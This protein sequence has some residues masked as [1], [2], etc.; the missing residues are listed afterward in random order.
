[1]EK[2]TYTKQFKLGAAKM[3]VDEKMKASR[4]CK[5]L[6]ISSS[7]LTRWIGDYKKHGSGAFPGKGLLAP[8]HDELRQLQRENRRLT[9]E[10]DLLKKTI[11]FFAGQDNKG[12]TP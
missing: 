3:V 5:D 12:T 6:G 11:V 9:M 10:R 2:K 8:A 4:V 1:M 7:A